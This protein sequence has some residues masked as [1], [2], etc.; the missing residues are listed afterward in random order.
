M[1]T[2]I[3]DL[4]IKIPKRMTK[5]AQ[6]QMEAFVQSLARRGKNVTVL[7][8]PVVVPKVRKV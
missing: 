8:G 1:T 6:Y 2:P 4:V 3:G 5:K 7:R